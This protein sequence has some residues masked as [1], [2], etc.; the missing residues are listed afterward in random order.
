[1]KAVVTGGAGFLGSFVV[2]RLRARGDEVVVPRSAD[3]DLRR[4][5]ACRGLI[6]DARPELVIHCAVNGG[7]IGWMRA[8]PGSVLHD[9]VTMSTHLM[10]A[11]RLGGVAKFVGVS[12]V[13]AYPRIVP[14]PMREADLFEGYP[15]PNNAGYGLAKRLM[16]EQGRAYA[17][18]YGF[19]AVFP[20]PTNLYG[21]RDVF[22]PERS[23]VVPALIKKCI[24]ARDAGADHI[25]AWGTGTATREL[26][27]VEDCADA[28]L[29][30]ADRYDSW[31][32]VNIGNGQEF[33]IRELVETVAKVCEFRGE[34]RW[35]TS[36]PDGQPRKCLD[37]SRATERF[38]WSAQ[39]DLESGLSRTVEWFEAQGSR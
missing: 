22:D 35:D 14:M 38:G 32:P 1:M 12:S 2:E 23:H 15:E 39:V 4:A 28:I 24:E 8:H 29:A 5:E 34:V 11:C 3:F 19:N 16:M 36:K 10:E 6:E 9:N 20:M 31:E 13:C 7:G 27:Y 25:V 18:E 21:P 37:T 17:K 33:T 30:M 26:L